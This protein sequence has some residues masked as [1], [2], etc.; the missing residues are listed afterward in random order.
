MATY[1]VRYAK[2]LG[3]MQRYAPAC[4][5]T[6]WYREVAVIE[7]HDLE[8]VFE[9][10][11]ERGDIRSM[12]VGDVVVDVSGTWHYCSVAGWE[13]KPTMELADVLG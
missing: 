2:N 11:Q 9:V 13:E 1:S 3:N 5:V 12:S 10:M 4:L 7:A 8:H 6:S